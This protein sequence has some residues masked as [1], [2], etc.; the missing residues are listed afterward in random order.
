MDIQYAGSVLLAL[1]N[2]QGDRP[3]P[4]TEAAVDAY[5]KRHAAADRFYPKVAPF[6]L[7]V[8]FGLMAIGVWLQ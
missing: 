3:R 8:G 7:A 6:V 2:A 4:T 1:Y 5:Y